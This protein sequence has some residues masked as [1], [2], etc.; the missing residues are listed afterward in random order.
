MVTATPEP[1]GPCPVCGFAGPQDR[2]WDD[3]VR[4][5]G[6]CGDDGGPICGFECTRGHWNLLRRKMTSNEARLFQDERERV[7][8]HEPEAHLQWARMWTAI[9]AALT[10]DKP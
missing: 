10:G 4:C 1:L 6:G 2:E 9:R 5:L 7:Y 8:E 3:V